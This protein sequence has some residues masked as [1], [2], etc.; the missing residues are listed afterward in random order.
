MKNGFTLVELS[1]V[2]LIIGLL[3]AAA[4]SAGKLIEQA[5]LKKIIT[6]IDERTTSYNTFV[7]TYDEIPG[8]HPGA[9]TFF[10]NCAQTASNCNG[11]GDGNIQSSTTVS[12]EITKAFVHMSLAE[13]ISDDITA[14]IPDAHDGSIEDYA[15]NSRI[16]GAKFFFGG[17]NTNIDSITPSSSMFIKNIGLYLGRF[18]TT[19]RRYND[20]AITGL[21]AYQIDKKIDDGRTSGG[22]AAGA[23]SGS[24]RAEDGVSSSNCATGTNY[25]VTSNTEGCFIGYSMK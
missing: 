10:P 25:N 7:Y 20:G 23:T 12:D 18:D 17:R 6:E 19:S 5:E 22:S 9:R 24:F 11:D 8:D 1:I 14:V 3:V 13:V 16:S 21:A 2:L 15:M 4:S